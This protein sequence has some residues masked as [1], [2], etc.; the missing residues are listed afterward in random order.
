M[1][2]KLTD[3]MREA[4]QQRAGRPVAVEDEQTRLQYVLLPLH[5]YQQLQSVFADETFDA[6]DAYA[7]QSLT[8]GAAGWDDPEMSIYEDYDAHRPLQRRCNVESHRDCVARTESS[9]VVAIS[10]S[11]TSVNQSPRPSQSLRECPPAMM[12]VAGIDASSPPAR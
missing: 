4:V 1:S 8:A 6:T 7:A 11:T 2:L 12:S 5:V 9:T 10:E 3:E